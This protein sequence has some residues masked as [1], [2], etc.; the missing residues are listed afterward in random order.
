MLT[1]V[2]LNLELLKDGVP[3]EILNELNYYDKA[4]QILNNSMTEMRRVAHHLM[5]DTLSRYGLKAALSDFLNDIPAVEFAWFG[6]DHRLDDQKKEVMIYR[7]INELINNALR[8]S[9]ATK[10]CVNVMCES[11]YIAFTV[12]DNG[13]GFDSTAEFKGVGLSNIRER[14]ASCNG[15]IDIHSKAGEGTE[16]NIELNVDKAQ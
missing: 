7:I 16:V 11:D 9:G 4:M 2:K 15:R 5:P 14:V 10:I 3:P 6:S 12:F 13:C 8:H 1:G